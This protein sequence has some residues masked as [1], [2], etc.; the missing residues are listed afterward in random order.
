MARAPDAPGRWLSPAG[1]RKK[2]WHAGSPAEPKG[3]DH[4]WR[5]RAMIKSIEQL[6]GA[7]GGDGYSAASD[8][9]PIGAQ[10]E[11][12]PLM[13][14]WYRE[15]GR[16]IESQLLLGRVRR[17]LSRIMARSQF[18]DSDVREVRSILKMIAV[19]EQGEPSTGA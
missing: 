15:R 17:L 3:P 8:V 7:R 18:T 4:E 12:E 10:S 2:H 1:G 14:A 11:V 13:E 6:V 5:T 16:N 19:I 9:L